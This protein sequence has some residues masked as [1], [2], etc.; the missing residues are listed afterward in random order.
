M[1]KLSQQ[2]QQRRERQQQRRERQRAAR[3]E[4][5]FVDADMV[6]VDNPNADPEFFLAPLRF[7]IPEDAPP[8]LVEVLTNSSGV[9]LPN[10]SVPVPT[11]GPESFNIENFVRDGLQGYVVPA[12]V[13]NPMAYMDRIT[14]ENILQFINGLGTVAP[15]IPPLPGCTAGQ[16]WVWIM[17]EAASAK[18]LFDWIMAVYNNVWNREPDFIKPGGKEEFLRLMKQGVQIIGRRC[19]DIAWERFDVWAEL[20]AQQAAGTPEPDPDRPAGFVLGL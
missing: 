2:Q 11:E 17:L 13:R 10:P 3:R 5:G 16:I 9:V 20:Q 14:Q 15:G 1:A 6:V 12:Y 19:E 18:D 4:V 8:E 7:S